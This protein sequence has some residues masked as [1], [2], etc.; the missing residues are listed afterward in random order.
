MK[1]LVSVIMPVYRAEKYIGESVESLLNQ[2]YENFE[3]ILIDDCGN[4]NSIDIVEK[5]ADSRFRIIRNPYNC[6]IAYS[7]NR[8]LECCEGELIA[9]LDDDDVCMS[10][11]FEK[12]VD[13]MNA[14]P[15]IDVVGGESVWIDEDG[16]IIRDRLPMPDNPDYIKTSFLFENMYNNSEVMVRKSLIAD[17]GISYRNGMM[18]MEDFCFWIDCSKNG[19]FSNLPEL[20]LKR[21]M[22]AE[23]TTS[24]I[25]IGNEKERAAVY[26]ALQKYSFEKS[27]FELS[28]MDYL[29]INEFINEKRR[30]TMVSRTMLGDFYEVLKKIAQQANQLGFADAAQVRLYLKERFKN[31]L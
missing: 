28:D 23:N 25:M 26:R 15:D 19:K 27:R 20:F 5:Y 4:D 1:P 12:Q 24:R 18:G 13:F 29:L 14:H 11:R 3:A 31:C 6:G 2:T 21:R 16:K 30:E 17:N 10:Q 9:I 7:R 8:G 22:V